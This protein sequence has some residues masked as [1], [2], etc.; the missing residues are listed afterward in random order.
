MLII[1]VGLPLQWFAVT[2][3]EKAKATKNVIIAKSNVKKWLIN[4]NRYIKSIDKIISEKKD[5]KAYLENL[6]NK[7]DQKRS[8]LE[9]YTAD[10]KSRETIYVIDY[11]VLKAE[12]E[13]IRLEERKMISMKNDI[14]MIV[15]EEAKEIDSKD[16][17][18]IPSSEKQEVEKR[19]LTLQWNLLKSSEDAFEIL[20]KYTAY[21]QSGSAEVKLS[22]DEESFGTLMWE[23]KIKEYNSKNNIFDSTFTG[24]VEW[25]LEYS[26][27]SQ[28]MKLEFSSF[29]DAIMKDDQLYIMLD[30]VISKIETEDEN[31][32]ALLD[33]SEKISTEGKYVRLSSENF[34]DI[35]ISREIID[36]TL[37][38]NQYKAL[39]EKPA[40]TVYKKEDNK[41]YLIP[42][43]SFCSEAKKAFWGILWKWS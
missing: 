16:S 21:E 17:D 31:L 23:L 24:N 20:Q 36:N 30:Q 12:L 3:S 7:L 10:K 26:I 32:S 28:D 38:I 25:K 11:I 40:F 41:Y 2:T 9:P 1:S 18:S 34:D 35:E 19:I 13:L 29:I 39:F 27:A 4:G 5:D 8:K 22:I 43:E 37:N 15:G 42:T 33:I 6:V 14:D